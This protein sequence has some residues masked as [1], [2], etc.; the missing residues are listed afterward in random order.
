MNARATQICHMQLG[1]DRDLLAPLRAVLSG[2]APRQTVPVTEGDVIA[3]F[4]QE[5][6]RDS[7]SKFLSTGYHDVPWDEPALLRECLTDTIEFRTWSRLSKAARATKAWLAG[8]SR[9][10]PE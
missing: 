7:T 1:T 9:H 3:L 10:A 4:P 2:E 5:W 6:L 8:T